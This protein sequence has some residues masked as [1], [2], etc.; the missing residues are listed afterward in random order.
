MDRKINMDEVCNELEDIKAIMDII[1]DAVMDGTV[2]KRGSKGEK[3][4]AVV[5]YR[6][7][8]STYLP[9]LVHVFCDILDL[10]RRVE[11]ASR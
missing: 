1:T 7:F 11:E 10:Y 3:F 5:F 8:H 2:E 4:A 6:R 9:A